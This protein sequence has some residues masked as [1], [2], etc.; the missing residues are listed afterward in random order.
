MDELLF[1]GFGGGAAQRGR[2]CGILVAATALLSF[3]K[4]D[5][6]NP[7]DKK[8]TYVILRNLYETVG[9]SFGGIRCKAIVGIDFLVREEACRYGTEKHEQVCKPIVNY[10]TQKVFEIIEG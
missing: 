6:K 1:A 10:V 7:S 3:F 5:S 2:L 9:K 8:D 4:M